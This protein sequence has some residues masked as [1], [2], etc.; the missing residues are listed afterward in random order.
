MHT[1]CILPG[2]EGPY[3]RL[4]CL[5]LLFL[6]P[7]HRTHAVLLLALRP[8]SK[9]CTRMYTHRVYLTWRF[10]YTCI[11]YLRCLELLLT[12]LL[13][14]GEDISLYRQLSSLHL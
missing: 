9:L 12:L 4:V 5:E 13:C 11:H 1:M 3:L 14:L 6:K 10:V 2:G 8:P 7:R